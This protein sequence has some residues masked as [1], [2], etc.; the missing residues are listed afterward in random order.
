MMSI[1]DNYINLV[2]KNH[3]TTLKYK[4]DFLIFL[5]KGY[6]SIFLRY[7]IFNHMMIYHFYH[8]PLDSTDNLDIKASANE[9]ICAKESHQHIFEKILIPVSWNTIF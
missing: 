2:V 1:S 8:F 7:D 4:L 3:T 5:L 9:F 6:F